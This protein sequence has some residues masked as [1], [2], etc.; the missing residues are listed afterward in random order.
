M[1]EKIRESLQSAIKRLFDADVVDEAAIKEFIKDIQRALIQADVNVKVVFD[2][3]K[4][5]EDRLL[6]EKTKPGISLKEQA[7]SILFDELTKIMGTETKLNPLPTEAYTILLVGI[8]G[9]GKTTAAGK[10]ARYFTRRGFKVGLVCADTFRAG[11]YDQLKTLGERTQTE[12]F[13][14]EKGEPED[15]AID[16]KKHFMAEG[17]QL[18]IVDTAGRHKEEKS[19]LD[20][21]KRIENSLRPNIA[22]L[23][24]DGTIGQQAYAQA[25]AFN[26]TTK[27]GGIIV[28]KL[29]GTAKGGGALAA[30]AATGAKIVF[31][32]AGERVDDLEEFSPSR[33]A[34]RMLGMGDLHGLLEKVKMAGTEVD[35]LT[36]KRITS[37]KMTLED[38]YAQMEQLNKLGPLQKIMEM[39]P[40][41]P[42]LEEGAAEQMEQRFKKWKAVIRGMTPQ[43]RKDPSLINSSRIRRIARGSGVSEKDVKEMMT[44]FEQGKK[45]MKSAKSMRMNKQL[46][47]Q[48]KGSGLA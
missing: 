23:V 26:S 27:V 39:L 43:E 35:E 20:E 2:L 11:A 12:V 33:F 46:M 16:G 6:A 37:G 44:A 22:L 28:T 21:M 14:E 30:A 47:R 32:S 10:L 48:L 13:W 34:G 25:A 8:Q 24:I 29:D 1:F 4:R 18:I 15:I 31:V 3:S 19:L 40:G 36:A 38:F 5:V 42:K 17:H 7:L 41:L 45:L 9:S